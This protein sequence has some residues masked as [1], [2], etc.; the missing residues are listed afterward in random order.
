M[1]QLRMYLTKL[2][3]GLAG[4]SFL[5]M[6]VLTC[7][8]VIT[9]YLL[10]N[11]STWSEELVSYLFAWMALLGASLIT[12]ERGHMNIPV[13]VER[14]P[15]K[16]KKGF[17]IFAEVVAFVFSAVILV[18]GG[19][20]I[21]SLAMGQ[22]TSSLGVAIGI[23]YVVLPL[24][25]ILNMIFTAMNIYDIVRGNIPVLP[26]SEEDTLVENLEKGEA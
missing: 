8:Q 24:S 3:N 17:A 10:K 16:A 9:R 13:V 20:Q 25:G 18:Y 6:V 12:S 23:F 19:V 11:P 2:L 26:T 5:V 15:E 4:I 21:T 7:W 1:K 22:M 14:L